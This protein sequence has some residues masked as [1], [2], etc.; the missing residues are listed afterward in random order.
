MVAERVDSQLGV[1]ADHRDLVENRLARPIQSG[2]IACRGRPVK[3]VGDAID[4]LQID[5]GGEEAFAGSVGFDDEVGARA[6]VA[7][8]VQLARGRIVRGP[9][10]NRDAVRQ[11]GQ[12][13][14]GLIVNVEAVGAL[15]ADPEGAVARRQAAAA[16]GQRLRVVH[17]VVG[18][19]D[20][21]ATAA[22][23]GRVAARGRVDSHAASVTAGNGGGCHRRRIGRVHADHAR[24]AHA[25]GDVQQFAVGV[26]RDFAAEPPLRI[27]IERS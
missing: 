20:A 10:P 9:R 6:R 12:G 16:P 13:P 4:R 17:R 8:C 2:D 5:V 15:R 26:D 23:G 22:V 1:L 19:V 3:L 27:E 24:L 18:I 11:R 7:V 25:R 21:Q 14:G